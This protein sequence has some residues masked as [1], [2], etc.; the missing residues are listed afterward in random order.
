MKKKPPNGIFKFCISV[1]TNVNTQ[2]LQELSV[3]A[4]FCFELAPMEKLK[5]EHNLT[6]FATTINTL[7][8]CDQ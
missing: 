3:L 6:H 2:F 5:Q 7:L 8:Y 4:Q 1:Y